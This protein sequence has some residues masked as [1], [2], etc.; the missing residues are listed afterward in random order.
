ME[1]DI[2]KAINKYCQDTKGY[3]I[4]P[5]ADK[6]PLEPYISK[7]VNGCETYL[8]HAC[9]VFDTGRYNFHIF[10]QNSREFIR[11]IKEIKSARS[12]ILGALENVLSSNGIILDKGFG[13]KG[14]IN[15]LRDSKFLEEC[16]KIN[17]NEKINL[18][19]DGL[20]KAIRVAQG[21]YCYY[22]VFM[23]YICDEKGKVGAK[24]PAIQFH[25]DTGNI[26]QGD[27]GFEICYPQTDKDFDFNIN[28]NGHICYN[29]PVDWPRIDE[30]TG[31]YDTN[32]INEIIGRFLD[33]INTHGD[34]LSTP[35]RNQKDFGKDY[36]EKCQNTNNS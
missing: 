21:K 11:L 27:S 2:N 18:N 20:Y 28:S 5:I 22:I 19:T 32:D 12:A 36:L 1:K 31:Q 3:D 29:P 7:T 26:N 15:R 9:V 17:L 6:H 16:K 24:I 14:Y 25:K 8:T 4:A 33:F 30:K 10:P 35:E 13:S 34:F 23:R